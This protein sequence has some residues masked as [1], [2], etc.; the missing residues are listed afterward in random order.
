MKV[1][2]NYPWKT[3]S[4]SEDQCALRGCLPHKKIGVGSSTVIT[5]VVTLHTVLLNG[6]NKFE[7]TRDTSDHDEEG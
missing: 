3:I 1:L 7:G 4:P 2:I 5:V 6:D